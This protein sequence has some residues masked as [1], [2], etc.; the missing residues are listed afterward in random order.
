MRIHKTSIV[1]VHH[2]DKYSHEYVHVHGVDLP[3]GRTYKVEF[4]SR[5]NEM[6]I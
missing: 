4:L 6:N 5:M 2:I 3:I 1:A